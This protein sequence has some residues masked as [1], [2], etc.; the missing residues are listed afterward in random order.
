MTLTDQLP[1]GTWTLGGANAADC[2]INGSNLLTCDFGDLADE[3][4]AT[5]TVSK[6]TVADDC[7]TIHNDV[8]VAASNE[9]TAT[10]Q[11]PNSDGADIVVN[12]P[13][14]TVIKTGNG[15]ISAGQLATFDI[16]VTNL[17]P[18]T[19]FGV[20]LSDQLPAGTWTL[21]G[22]DAGRLLDRWQQPP[23]MR[24]RR[25]RQRHLPDDLAQP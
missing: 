13:D 17:G 21:G 25:S 6:T 12:C 7:G 18:G 1:S 3:A 22:P 19:A 15:T 8:T 10:D 14:V 16:A 4:S 2:A 23:D 11:F 5:F 24:L 9:D 20:T